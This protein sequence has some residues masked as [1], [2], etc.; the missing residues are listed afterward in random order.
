LER[1]RR[2]SRQPVAAVKGDLKMA[3]QL[4]ELEVVAA[5]VHTD[6]IEKKRAAGVASRKSVD[7]EELMVPYD[8]LSEAAKNLDR[9]TVKV[10]YA[11]IFTA[12][13]RN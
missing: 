12:A 8:K 6:W 3:L 1:V 2:E 9:D 10:V 7:G 4:P 11:A 13:A 5:A